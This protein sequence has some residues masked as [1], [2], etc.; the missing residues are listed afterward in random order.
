VVGFEFLARTGG[1]VMSEGGYNQT[2]LLW[3]PDRDSHWAR[4]TTLFNL[5]DAYTAAIGNSSLVNWCDSIAH[6]A[7]NHD[8]I[9]FS[10]FAAAPDNVWHVAL[11]I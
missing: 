10:I 2:G 11:D 1:V 6:A 9:M 4:G 5:I 3:D 8:L 7:S